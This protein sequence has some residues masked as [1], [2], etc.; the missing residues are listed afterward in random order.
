MDQAHDF[1][2]RESVRDGEPDRAGVL[3]KEVAAGCVWS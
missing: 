3:L 1:E 2:P